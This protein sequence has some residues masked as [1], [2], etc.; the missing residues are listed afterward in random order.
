MQI[1]PVL[2]HS[3]HFRNKALSWMSCPNCCVKRV[4]CLCEVKMKSFFSTLHTQLTLP[5]ADFNKILQWKCTDFLIWCLKLQH[6]LFL[7]TF[8]Q[9]ASWLKSIKSVACDCTD[10]TTVNTVK[11]VAT[12]TI[13]VVQRYSQQVLFTDPDR[14]SSSA[15]PGFAL[16]DGCTRLECNFPSAASEKQCTL[17]IYSRTKHSR[18]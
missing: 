10:K 2:C 4:K 5:E 6:I 11:I 18:L 13:P 15:A 8:S 16:W 12:T 3:F 17:F 14:I 9:T 1:D 7:K